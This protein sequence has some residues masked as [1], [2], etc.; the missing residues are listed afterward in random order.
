MTARR[1]QAGRTKD[2]GWQ[3][4]VSK[5]VDHPVEQVWDFL[6]SAE[7]TALWLGHGVTALDDVG[8]QYE[9]SDGTVGESRSFRDRDRIRLTWRPAGWTH[10]T[11]VQVALT[12]SGPGRTMIRFHQERLADAQE[13]EQQRAHWQSVMVT[14]VDAL[15]T[16]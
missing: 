1:A 14:V 5:T 15:D 9:T 10:D 8:A 12:S 13:R 7:G 16:A 4:G 11:T 6:T 2:A 3:I